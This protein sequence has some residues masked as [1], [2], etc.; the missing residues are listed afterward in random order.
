[1]GAF[2]FLPGAGDTDAL[3]G[4]V[5]VAQAG[6][7]DDVQGYTVDVDFLDDLVAGRAGDGGDDGDVVAGQGV[8]QAGF[9][10]V[11]FAGQ[12]DMQAFAQDD[13]LAGLGDQGVEVCCQRLQ[14]GTRLIFFEEIDFLFGEIQ[15][16]LDQHAQV[17]DSVRQC[18]DPG[19]ELARQRGHGAARR[20]DRRGVDQ[21][22]DGLGLG[23]VHAIV[24]K[25]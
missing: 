24:Q 2:D 18:V 10:D 16:G 19:G 4:V 22:G 15:G 11:G 5:G 7:V 12:H 21:V 17:D 1:V 6:G 14:R 3:D 20:S 8:Q 23:Q 13:A 9:T 25:G